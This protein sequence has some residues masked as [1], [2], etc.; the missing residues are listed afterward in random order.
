MAEG[1][2]LKYA[3]EGDHFLDHYT[4]T[5]FN[6]FA[7]V[8]NAN[9]FGDPSQRGV[10]LDY[11]HNPNIVTLR[12]DS[13]ATRGRYDILA[14]SDL[15]V[16]PSDNLAS[17]QSS[18]LWTGT[19]PTLASFGR[20]AILI[21]PVGTHVN[22]KWGRA[23]IAGQWQTKLNVIHEKHEYADIAAGS[24]RLTSGWYGTS[25]IIKK[26]SGTGEKW[27]VVRLGC[28]FLGVIDGITAQSISGG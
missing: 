5:A 7:A 13:A 14:L 25:Q 3:R 21:D 27:G 22:N 16:S 24:A 10:P 19:L 28:P 26:E 20:F 11:S 2:F 12:N 15:V 23:A 17:F 1:G 4:A 8:V 6:R 9:N 18:A